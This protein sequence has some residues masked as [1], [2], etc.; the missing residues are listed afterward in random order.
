MDNQIKEKLGYHYTSIETLKSLLDGI[1]DESII[2]HASSVFYMNDPTEMKYGFNKMMDI[3]PD[4]ENELSVEE[5]IYKLS[6]LWDK[7]PQYKYEQW[8]SYRYLWWWK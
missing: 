3:L 8:K 4:I 7:S 6:K 2:F 5:D 1:C